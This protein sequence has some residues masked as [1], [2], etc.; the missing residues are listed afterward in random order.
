MT[1][2][3]VSKGKRYRVLVDDKYADIVRQFT[4]CRKPTGYIYTQTGGRKNRKTIYLHRLVTGAN[5]GEE[6]D[7]I[8][9]NPA[10]NR[11]SNLRLC[12]RS[13]NNMNKQGVRG[14]S[15][16]RDKWRARIK[17]NNTDKHIGLFETKEKAV[18]ARRKVEKQLFKEY[19]NV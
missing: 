3:V 6:V 14:V 17:I 7:H 1:F 4:W 10:D 13:Q 9:R 2:Y 15:P 8:N 16:F 11:C 19:A 5:K 18:A 12:S